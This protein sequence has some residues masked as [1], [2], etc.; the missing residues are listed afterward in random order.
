MRRQIAFAAEDAW[1]ERVLHLKRVE[2]GLS[3]TEQIEVLKAR[4]EALE[5][6]LDTWGWL[7][8]FRD[9]FERGP[10]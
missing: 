2:G 10:R 5:V 6:V 3:E 8:P 4:V 7:K 1:H 9:E